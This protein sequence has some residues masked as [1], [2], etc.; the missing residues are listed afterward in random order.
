MKGRLSVREEQILKNVSSEKFT[1]KD[2][3]ARCSELVSLEN[4]GLVKR[5]GMTGPR[6]RTTVWKKVM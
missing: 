4:K 6:N 1:S 3:G 2:V 5:C